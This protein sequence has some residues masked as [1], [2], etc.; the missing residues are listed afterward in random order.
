MTTV[1]AYAA[2]YS[3]GDAWY[4]VTVF[5]SSAQHAKQLLADKLPVEVPRYGHGAQRQRKYRGPM[6]PAGSLVTGKPEIISI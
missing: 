5:A 6:L 3:V 2:G 1:Y 4:P